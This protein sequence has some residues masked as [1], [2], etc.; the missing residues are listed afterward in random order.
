MIALRPYQVD[1]VERVRA[2]LRTG[3]R[4]VLFVLPTGGGKTVVA[5]HV[6]ASA[7]A[8]LSRVLFVAHRRELIK[9]AFCKLVR[10]G[11]APSSIGII[12]AGVESKL[13]DAIAPSPA[14]LS[15][16]ELWRIYA[17]RRPTA[18]VQI[19]SVDTLRNR[20]NPPADLVIID[21]AHRCLAASYRALVDGYPSAVHIGLT[22]T[23]WRADGRGL[24]EVYEDLVAI[25]TPRELIDLGFLV[26]PRVF[27]VPA[28]D[29][30][31]LSGIRMKGNDYDE[32][33]LAIAVDKIGLVGNIVEH[34]QKHSGWQRTVAFAA[35]VAH[36]RHIADRFKSA[37]I[38]AEH[39]DGE[40]PAHER[41]AIL[42]RLERGETLVVSN[43]G[44]LCEGWD[45]PSVKCCILARPTKSTGLYL[46]QAGRI[47]RPWEN[48]RAII[49]DHAGCALEHGLPQD[50]REFSLTS[51]RKR[52]AGPTATP[53][54][55][56]E[57]CYAVLPI[58]AKVC[59][60]CGFVFAAGE[61]REV[62]EE[63]MGELI[64]VRP[65]SVDEKKAYWDHLCHVA[66]ERGYKSGWAFYRYKEKFGVAPQWKA[67]QSERATYTEDEKRS[68]LARLVTLGRERGYDPAWALIRYQAKFKEDVPLAWLSPPESKVEVVA[69]PL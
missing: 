62:P 13:V 8:L 16:D 34:W 56:C 12:M 24:G 29:L 64:E 39:L 50:E 45:Q 32:K 10:N 20:Q 51:S 19:A 31:D 58:S 33:A 43:C 28:K 68:E 5:A 44:V 38:A 9:Q 6:V 18:A 3:K 14:T 35:S 7:I 21:E 26:E 52:K 25:A 53:C 46:Q 11:I 41:D 65:A 42:G 27:T 17:R 23:P 61:S 57:D 69:W 22:A 36:S 66:A 49:L 30:P 47:L 1:G 2:K 59:P 4:R 63:A 37:G 48:A 54:R 67:P 40:T 15:D 60:E 55:T